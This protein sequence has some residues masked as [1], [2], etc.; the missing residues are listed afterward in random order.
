MFSR[1]SQFST[2]PVSL[3][4]MAAFVGVGL[5]MFQPWTGA[6]SASPGQGSDAPLPPSLRVD[7]PV[8]VTS[9]ANVVRHLVVPLALRGEQGISL[10]GA[11]LRAETEMS[12]TAA[13][14]VPAGYSLNWLD[15]NGDSVIDA[16]EHVELMV[17]LPAVTSVHP[18][19]PLTLVF[20]TTDGGS[21][22]LVDVLP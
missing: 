7:G 20:R 13:A 3:L 18:D 6:Q 14:A 19:N 22:S 8:Q 21:L 10:D 15:G 11:T 16:G 12:A 1:P 2:R 9:D 17:D 4:L 5:W